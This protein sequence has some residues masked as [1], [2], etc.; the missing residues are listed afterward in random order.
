MKKLL[1]FASLIVYAISDG[2]WKSCE[3]KCEKDKGNFDKF[4]SCMMGCIDN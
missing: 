3:M 1:V 2:D 4:M